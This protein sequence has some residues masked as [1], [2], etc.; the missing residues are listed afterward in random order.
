MK[1]TGPQAMSP[2]HVVRS[3]PARSQTS[4]GRRRVSSTPAIGRTKT[5]PST[6][7]AP[8]TG[9]TIPNMGVRVG[10]RR[11]PLEGARDEGTP[12][13]VPSS[14]FGRLR[15]LDVDARDGAADDEPLD[16][17]G[18]L[19]D[20]VDLRVAVPPLDGVLPH[21]AVATEDLD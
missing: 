5:S 21:V 8:S 13:G 6:A 2:I 17:R 14:R 3:S 10:T 4:P 20:R 19:E 16:L 12:P 7:A 18:A 1:N 15:L 11:E 9:R